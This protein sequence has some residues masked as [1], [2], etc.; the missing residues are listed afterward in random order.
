[1]EGVLKAG[2]TI[3]RYRIEALVG[4]GGMAAVYR[5]R[6]TQLDSA[7]AIK[8]LFVTV[9][10][11]R[12]RLLREGKVQANLRHTN[13]VSVTDVLEVQGSPALVMEFVDGPSLDQW[14]QDHRP[15]LDEARWIFRGI[16]RGISAAHDRGV[17]HRDLKPANVLLAPTSE[18]LAPKV[19]DFGLVKSLTTGEAHTQTGMALGTPEYMSPEQ[20]RDASKVDQRTDMWAL[21]CILYELV[22]GQRPF[23]GPDRISVFNRI[24]AGDFQPPRECVPDLPDDLDAAIHSLLTLDPAQR[25]AKASDLAAVLYPQGTPPPPPGQLRVPEGWS[26]PLLTDMPLSF[27]DDETDEGDVTAIKPSATDLLHEVRTAEP[28]LSRFLGQTGSAPPSTRA[29]AEFPGY[30]DPPR[31]SLG[32]SMVIPVMVA[33]AVGLFL[34]WWLVLPQPEPA[35]PSPATELHR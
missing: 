9:P 11:L 34:A 10:S 15:T 26:P 30:R 3:D 22:C 21:G 6:H 18:G 29:T 25:L 31:G 35:P 14:L 20:I 1:M 13:I 23:T 33:T 19:T 2:V 27:R 5:A 12:Q 32:W 24:V 17:V 16:V 7:H 28:A 4:Q 8:L